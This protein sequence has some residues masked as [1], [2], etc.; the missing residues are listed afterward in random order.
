MSGSSNAVAAA[1]FW[2]TGLLTGELATVVAVLAVA[3]IGF[4]MLSGR[5]D[6][7]AA[8]RVLLGCF[9]LFGASVLS[10]VFL[11]LAV[12]PNVADQPVP[13]PVVAAIPVSLPP[14]QASKSVPY[15][16]YAGAAVQR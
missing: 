10:S 3:G 14:A 13:A 9:I 6:A 4:L 8:L 16:P 15:D 7:R 11:R 2:L 12:A 5:T 1:L